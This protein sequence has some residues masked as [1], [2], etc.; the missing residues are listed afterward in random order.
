MK[1]V[2][3]F[4]SSGAP[5]TAPFGTSW[6]NAWRRLAG[7]GP[8][9]HAGHALPALAF[10]APSASA[11]RT[12]LRQ[13]APGERHPVLRVDDTGF[14]VMY[15]AGAA[16]L[17]RRD[18]RR[19][20]LSE[21]ALHQQAL[22]NLAAQATQGTRPLRCVCLPQRLFALTLGDDHASSLVLLDALWDER[23]STRLCRRP[24]VSIPS[25]ELCVFADA[26][27]AV[28]LGALR[29]FTTR[30]TCNPQRRRQLLSSALYLRREGGWRPIV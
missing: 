29:Q 17:T 21:P 4:A 23:I 26:T 19:A 9:L 7:G 27:D 16:A 25:R 28:A 6:R 20:G 18:L 30:V 1:R 24:V 22:S 2:P 8:P 3:A 10:A 14:G 5:G 11:V 12:L 13:A 15:V